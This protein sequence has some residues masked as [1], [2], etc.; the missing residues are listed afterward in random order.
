MFGQGK[1]FFQHLN[2][3]SSKCHFCFVG[4]G[5]CHCPGSAAYNIRRYLWSKKY[6]PFG[7]EFPV[8]EGPTPD[9]TSVYSN[10]TGSRQRDLARWTNVGGSITVGGRP[11]YSSSAVTISRINNEVVVK[12]IRKIANPPSDPDAE[13]SDELDGGEV[14]VVNNPVGQQ[15]ITSPS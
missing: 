3:K 1:R 11:L 15:S 9:F 12:R 8:S 13:G 6:G 2:P 5:P 7:K 4:K 10:L 14:E